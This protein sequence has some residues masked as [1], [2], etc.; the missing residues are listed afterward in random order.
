MKDYKRR[1]H[2]HKQR[3][4]C[5]VCSRRPQHH[6]DSVGA[7]LARIRLRASNSRR[8][9]ELAVEHARRRH[10]LVLFLLDQIF[11]EYV[12]HA[13]LYKITRKIV[14]FMCMV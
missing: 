3:Y 1:A 14:I 4:A 9:D 13:M 10:V 12:V 5:C 8:H 6:G 7:A 2:K 11:I